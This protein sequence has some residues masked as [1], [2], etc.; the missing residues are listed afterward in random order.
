MARRAYGAHRTMT[1]QQKAR[2]VGQSIRLREVE[3]V[4]WTWDMYGLTADSAQAALVRQWLAAHTDVV[5]R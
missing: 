5:P 1:P 4:I 2:N 3:G